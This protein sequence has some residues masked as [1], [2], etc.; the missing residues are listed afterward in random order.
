MIIITKIDK[1]ECQTVN[2]QKDDSYH[3]ISYTTPRPRTWIQR[4]SAKS[5]KLNLR[6]CSSGSL[7]GAR[8]CR[9]EIESFGEFLKSC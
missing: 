4:P 2:T 9:L 7:V 8:E 3:K 6:T 1:E 5:Q